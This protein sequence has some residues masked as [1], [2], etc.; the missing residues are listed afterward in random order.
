MI[1]YSF[2]RG[3]DFSKIDFPWH[4]H[5]DALKLI[6]GIFK[7]RYLVYGSCSI[8]RPFIRIYHS[9]MGH[10]MVRKLTGALPLI[11]ITCSKIYI[12]I[13]TRRKSKFHVQTHSKLCGSPMHWTCEKIN[14]TIQTVG[15]IS[16]T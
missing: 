4:V 6:V 5:K 10:I 7:S 14:R 16:P 3:E 1:V 13:Y 12:Y 8:V 2:V 11:I 15:I 9:D